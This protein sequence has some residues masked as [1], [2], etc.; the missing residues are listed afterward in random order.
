MPPAIPPH[1]WGGAPPQGFPPGPGFPGFAP[2]N[3][4]PPGPAPAAAPPEA[5]KGPPTF[6]VFDDPMFS[7]EEI[8]SKLDRYN[9]T[10][11]RLQ[12]QYN[13]VGQSVDSRLSAIGFLNGG[14]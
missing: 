1:N 10:A 5:D 2:Q 6:V 13:R 9:V 14:R 4:Y 12:Q 8:R 3:A 11:E 7:M